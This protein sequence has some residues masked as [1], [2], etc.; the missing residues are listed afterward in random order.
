[1][2]FHKC[3]RCKCVI[4]D[5]E[6]ILF[7]GVNRNKTKQEHIHPFFGVCKEFENQIWELCTDCAM[8]IFRWLAHIE[9][10]LKQ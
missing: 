3:D 7:S 4:E 6:P 1:M 2:E 5:Y 9:N 8:E 10:E